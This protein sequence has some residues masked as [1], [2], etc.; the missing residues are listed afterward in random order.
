MDLSK[1]LDTLNHEILLY[2][3]RYYG[4]SGVALDWFNNYLANRTQYTELNYNI[5]SPRKYIT[6]CVPQGP[7]LDLL[8]FLIY[9]NDLPN[10]NEMFK[11]ISFA[12]DNDTV[13]LCLQSI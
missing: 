12:D 7:I 13:H 6:A 9:M 11:F 5:S 2:K 10:A 8:L 1:A 3:L 4:I